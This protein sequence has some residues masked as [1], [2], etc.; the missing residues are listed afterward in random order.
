M[1]GLQSM[2]TGIIEC[3]GI[4][5]SKNKKESGFEFEVKSSL[6]LGDLKRGDSIAINGACQTVT[7][8]PKTKNAFF[9][10]FHIQND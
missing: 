9:F 2:F 4:V 8:I 10:L 6:K 1:G 7:E 5:Q 3:T